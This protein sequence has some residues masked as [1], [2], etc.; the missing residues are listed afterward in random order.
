M[1]HSGY[2]ASGVNYTFGSLKGMYDTVKAMLFDSYEDDGALK[3]MNE[4]KPAH[5]APLVQISATAQTDSAM[6]EISG[7]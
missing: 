7:D 2:E 5:A 6:Q 3:L 4:W 1:V